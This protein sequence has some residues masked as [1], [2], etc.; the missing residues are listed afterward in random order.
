MKYRI[1]TPIVEAFRY[2]VDQ[3]PLWFRQ[4]CEALGAVIFPE[5]CEIRTT[6]GN[7]RAEKGD[8]IVQHGSG[9][10]AYTPEVFARTYEAIEEKKPEK[11]EPEKKEPAGKK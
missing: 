10:M 3:V 11:K 6:A 5:Y 8:W 4:A 7:V 9:M 2:Q 1:N